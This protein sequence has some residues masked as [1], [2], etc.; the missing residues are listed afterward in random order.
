[1]VTD[2]Q[3]FD[4]TSGFIWPN[5]CPRAACP[6]LW[7]CGFWRSSR[8]PHS[9][10]EVCATASS[11]TQH[12]SAS[13][14]L[15]GTSY[16]PIHAHGI[17][18]WYW[19]AMRR[20]WLCSLCILPSGTVDI[21][22]ILP[23]LFFSR[24]DISAHHCPHFEV[25]SHISPTCKNSAHALPILSDFRDKADKAALQNRQLNGTLSTNWQLCYP[26]K[27]AKNILSFISNTCTITRTDSTF[28]QST[29]QF[30]IEWN[31]DRGYCWQPN[32][33]ECLKSSLCLIQ[34]LAFDWQI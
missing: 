34:A 26:L 14:C 15:D 3:R 16:V 7:S 9:L 25:F 30:S 18:S 33:S 27:W 2:R 29:S 10:W 6:G 12:R 24:L 23:C 22:E 32:L 13:S 11:P 20:A 8:R 1:M 21:D 17:L 4:G 19:A 28:Q 31:N 5:S